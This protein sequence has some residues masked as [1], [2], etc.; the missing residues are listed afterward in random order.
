MTGVQTCALPICGRIALDELHRPEGSIVLEARNIDAI[1][2]KLGSPV[3]ASVVTGLFGSRVSSGQ[4]SAPNSI[5]F[6]MRDGQVFAGFLPLPY[7]LRPVY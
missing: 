4:P 5:T 1:A 6:Q 2:Q 3:I 7:R